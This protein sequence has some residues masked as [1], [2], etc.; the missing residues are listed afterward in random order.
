MT[1]RLSTPRTGA[2]AQPRRLPDSPR[3]VGAPSTPRRGL[4][5][6]ATGRG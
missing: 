4:S 5:S 6:A 1:P 2:A 3:R